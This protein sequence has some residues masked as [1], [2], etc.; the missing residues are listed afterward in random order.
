[1]IKKAG[2]KLAFFV[3]TE[4]IIIGAVKKRVAIE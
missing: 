4:Y 1:M 2:N 3:R